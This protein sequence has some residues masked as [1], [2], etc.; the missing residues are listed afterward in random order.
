MKVI[1]SIWIITALLLGCSTEERKQLAE[2][3]QKPI[4][5]FTN[6]GIDT[7]LTQGK[8]IGFWEDFKKAVLTNDSARIIALSASCIT[9]SMEDT[10]GYFPVNI[11]YKKYYTQIFD[12]NLLSRM[13]DTAKVRGRYDDANW[14]IYSQNCIFKSSDLKKPKIAE[15]FIKISDPNSFYQGWEGADAA[16]A[17]IETKSGYKFCGYSTI[18]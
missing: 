8:L 17:F 18:P 5:K 1:F 14:H 13:N 2:Q 7:L 10:S 11:F 3:P 15:I 6:N 4:L 12:S 9:C 16:L